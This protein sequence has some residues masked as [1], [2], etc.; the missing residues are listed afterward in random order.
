MEGKRYGDIKNKVPLSIVE[1]NALWHSCRQLMITNSRGNVMHVATNEDRMK[2]KEYL[3]EAVK[4]TMRKKDEEAHIRDILKTLKEMHDIEPKISRKVIG[5]MMK[6]NFP[7]M[8]EENDQ[9]HDLAEIV[10]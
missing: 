3:G 10:L 9:L 1:Y 7:E 6:G 2:I 4:A 8:K 5:A